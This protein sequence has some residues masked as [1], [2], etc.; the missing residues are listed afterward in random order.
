WNLLA[1]KGTIFAGARGAPYQDRDY[2]AKP[3]CGGLTKRTQSATFLE[4]CY[5]HLP[6]SDISPS[7]Y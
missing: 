6:A 2:S 3:A 7:L 1:A 4:A 5:L